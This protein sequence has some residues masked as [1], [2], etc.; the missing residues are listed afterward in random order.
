MS[1]PTATNLD[2]HSHRQPSIFARWPVLT[3]IAVGVVSL[4]PHAFLAPDDSVG[5]AAILIA[6]IAGI[7][8]GFA[9]MNGSPRVQLGFRRNEIEERHY[10]GQVS[11][12]RVGQQSPGAV[13]LRNGLQHT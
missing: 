5:F 3:G 11:C 13:E 10:P 9:V 12:I 2:P 1:S 6:L 8:F 7:Y 4:V